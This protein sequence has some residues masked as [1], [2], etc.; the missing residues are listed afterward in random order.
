MVAITVQTESAST[1]ANV[2]EVEPGL[3]LARSHPN[4]RT[5]AYGRSSDEALRKLARK[6]ELSEDAAA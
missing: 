6:I 1:Y 3:F 5:Q 2:E 4:V